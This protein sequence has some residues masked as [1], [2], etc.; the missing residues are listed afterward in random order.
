MPMTQ[1]CTSGSISRR[2]SPEEEPLTSHRPCQPWTPQPTTAAPSGPIS[3]PDR[4]GIMARKPH[5][6]VTRS[7]SRPTHTPELE[8]PSPS[9]RKFGTSAGVYLMATKASDIRAPYAD[10]CR[11]SQP[12]VEATAC[13][14]EQSPHDRWYQPLIGALTDPQ[15]R[16]HR[17]IRGHRADLQGVRSPQF[18][19]RAGAF[20]TAPRGRPPISSRSGHPRVGPGGRAVKAVVRE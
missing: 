13:D 1:A 17:T 3:R 7:E 16:R 15:P 8:G 19:C 18:P 10:A 20:K 12:S 14:Q 5:P 2:T 6:I 4:R 9:S 11:G